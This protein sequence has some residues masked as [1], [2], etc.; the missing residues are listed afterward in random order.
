ML[1]SKE[2]DDTNIIIIIPWR[3]QEVESRQ[4]EVANSR[5]TL[6]G[7]KIKVGQSGWSPWQHLNSV[8]KHLSS[9]EGMASKNSTSRVTCHSLRTL[10]S[11]FQT[12]F[13][14]QL[15]SGVLSLIASKNSTIRWTLAIRRVNQSFFRTQRGKRT[16]TGQRHVFGCWDD[17][18][19]IE[20][21]DL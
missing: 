15:N 19:S 5:R 11:C 20:I 8:W 13:V 10:F 17:I 2:D 18:C 3:R 16:R 1:K 7:N 12:N 4:R 21:V 9:D 6:R 14:W